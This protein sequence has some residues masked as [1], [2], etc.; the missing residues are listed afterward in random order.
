MSTTAPSLGARLIAGIDRFNDHVG[1]ATAWC[2]IAMVLMQ[3]AV[4]V[5]RYVFGIGVI[6]MQESIVYMHAVLFMIGAGYTLLH[7]GHVRV[8]VFY[9]EMPGR[10]KAM[11]DLAGA[12]VFVI[13]IC[14]LVMDVSWPYVSNSWKVLE[15]SKETS[16][17]PAI[18]LLKSTILAFAVLVMLQALSMALRAVLILQGAT[19]PGKPLDGAHEGRQDIDDPAP[20]TEGAP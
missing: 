16:G 2:A 8:D 6:W 1:R 9:R 13:P 10:R 11:V 7:D 15:G 17:I 3:F 18:F 12:L 20:N 19:P 4:V 5:L 14:I